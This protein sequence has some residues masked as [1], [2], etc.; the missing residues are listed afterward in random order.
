MK[1]GDAGVH[2]TVLILPSNDAQAPTALGASAMLLLDVVGGLFPDSGVPLNL[3]AFLSRVSCLIQ[4][5]LLGAVA[6][7][8]QRRWRSDC[9]F[10]GQTGVLARLTQPPWWAWFASSAAIAGWLGR[11]AAQ[12]AVG[13]F[14]NSSQ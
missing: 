11:I 5:F 4:G 9:L 7:R 8:Y 10:C 2:A 14:A 12:V 13:W 3:P 1:P 6:V